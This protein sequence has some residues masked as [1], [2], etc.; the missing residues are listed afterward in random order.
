MTAKDNY[1]LQD[2]ENLSSP[3]QMQLCFKPTIFF[4]FF[5][6]FSNLHQI[7]HILKKM[8]IVIAALFRKLQTVTELVRPLFKKHRFRNSFDNQHVKDF[9]NLVKYA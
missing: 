5:L 6:H 9:Q 3:I 4:D 8:I 1:P 2:C 7:L